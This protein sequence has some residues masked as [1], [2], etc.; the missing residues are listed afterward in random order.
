[1]RLMRCSS[2]SMQR[3]PTWS[4]KLQKRF[5]NRALHAFAGIV[6]AFALASAGVKAED[7]Y[8]SRPVRMV[9]SFAAG[10]PTDTVAR[11]MGARM[12]DLLGQQ[13]LIENKT[14]AGG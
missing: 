10:G 11:I 12:A 5:M 6:I 1:M 13:F 7:R 8:P 2:S 14:G 3:R 4:Q 9:V